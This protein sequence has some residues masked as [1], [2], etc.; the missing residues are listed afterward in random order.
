MTYTRIT[1]YNFFSPLVVI[2]MYSYTFRLT[3]LIH[4]FTTGV[5]SGFQR[6]AKSINQYTGLYSYIEKI[7][8]YRET[9]KSQHFSVQ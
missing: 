5:Q 9:Q 1:K 4:F 3:D 6:G 2:I 7:T 8:I